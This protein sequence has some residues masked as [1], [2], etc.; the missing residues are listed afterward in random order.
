MAV[1]MTHDGKNVGVVE[2]KPSPSINSSSNSSSADSANDLPDSV[3][4]FDCVKAYNDNIDKG[5]AQEVLK[6]KMADKG[7]GQDVFI[8]VD[9]KVLQNT[10][11]P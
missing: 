3:F 9:K 7:D 5:M 10:N 8:V 2:M 4:M 6:C 11:N 1:M